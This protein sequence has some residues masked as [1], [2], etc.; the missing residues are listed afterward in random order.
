MILIPQ[1]SA[2][3]VSI[4]AEAQSH[5]GGRRVPAA[6]R[7]TVGAEIAQG[8]VGD[9]KP[10]LYVANENEGAITTQLEAFLRRNVRFGRSL[11]FD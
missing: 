6:C 7:P 9:V 11:G 3:I 4:R 10:V 2:Y 1:S 8:S 5:C